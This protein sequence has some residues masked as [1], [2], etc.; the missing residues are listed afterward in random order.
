MKKILITGGP[1]HGKLDDVKLITNRFKGGLIAKLADELAETEQ[2]IYL[3]AK[4][5]TLPKN[6]NIEKLKARILGSMAS[7]SM[8]LREDADGDCDFVED[9]AD[10]ICTLNDNDMQHFKNIAADFGFSNDKYNNIR[11]RKKRMMKNRV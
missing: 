2:I 6:T 8:I 4:G 9:L 3:T 7:L 5:A 11:Q 10:L 1:V